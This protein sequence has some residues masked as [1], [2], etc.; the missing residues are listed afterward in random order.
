MFIYNNESK[1]YKIVDADP[2]DEL[3]PKLES[4]IYNLKVEKTMFGKN[5]YLNDI[6]GAYSKG[7]IIDAGI[8][9]TIRSKVDTFLDP[10]MD[11]AR[12]AMGLKSKIGMIFN[13]KPGTGK[14]FLAGQIA[15]ELVEKIDAVGIVV[16]DDLDLS[17]FVTRIRRYDPDRFIVLILDEFEKVF[18]MRYADSNLLGFLDGSKSKEKCITIATVNS[19]GRM[20]DVFTERPGRFEEIYEFSIDDDEVLE[21]M[22]ESII[23]D[24]YRDKIDKKDIIKKMKAQKIYAMDRLALLV[25]DEIYALIKQIDSSEVQSGATLQKAASKTDHKE[26]KGFQYD[27]LPKSLDEFAEMI[28]TEI[29]DD[30]EYDDDACDEADF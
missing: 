4:G 27:N 2:K 28:N 15:T 24:A 9:K 12:T 19:T 8:F 17:E 23:P 1:Q 14:T 13:G 18:N 10:A 16:T 20:P 21:G 6:N 29:E 22:V 3:R 30:C 11:E 5:F 25:R 7:R 26:V